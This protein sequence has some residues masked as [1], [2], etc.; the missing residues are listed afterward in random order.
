MRRVLSKS[1][2]LIGNQNLSSTFHEGN[3]TNSV[4]IMNL[5]CSRMNLSTIIAEWLSVMIGYFVKAIIL[6]AERLKKSKR[7]CKKRLM[8]IK[9]YKKKKHMHRTVNE[10]KLI[11]INMDNLDNSK[12]LNRSKK[13][14]YL[15][16]AKTTH[17]SISQ[18]AK[19]FH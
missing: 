7:T 2:R 14:S 4:A 15:K 11:V 19:D 13:D 17:Q 10:L 9:I 5:S 6:A 3:L 18:I 16:N 8:F 1:T 12:V